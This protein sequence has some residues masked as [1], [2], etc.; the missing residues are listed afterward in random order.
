MAIDPTLSNTLAKQLLLQGIGLVQKIIPPL[1]DMLAEM[2]VS[3]VKNAFDVSDVC[4]SDLKMI[5][6]IEKRNN[7]LKI[8]NPTSKTI[9]SIIDILPIVSTTI[10]GIQLGITATEIAIT[11]QKAALVA[12][13]IPPAAFTVGP[14]T[15]ALSTIQDVLDKKIK[16]TL[17]VTQIITASLELVL[18]IV[19]GIITKIIDMLNALD[20]KLIKCGSIF[21]P[22]QLDAVDPFLLKVYDQQKQ[23]QTKTPTSYNKADTTYKGFQLSAITGSYSAGPSSPKIPQLK[24][25]GKNVG[26]IIILET[27]WS[28]T[29]DPTPL[30][31]ELKFKIDKEQLKAY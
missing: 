13:I 24:G 12:A 21:D 4:P 18:P 20:F 17:L 28:F 10:E 11:S 25:I 9:K 14:Q 31:E 16:P 3:A 8:L 1:T 27:K 26:G 19:Y 23:Q 7:L 15:A 6:I 22:N 2:A 30:I 29:T 5:Q